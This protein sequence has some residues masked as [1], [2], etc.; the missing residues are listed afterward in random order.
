[1]SAKLAPVASALLFPTIVLAQAAQP[2]PYRDGS[3]WGPWHMMGWGW[4][5]GWIFPLFMIFMIVLCVFF[6]A[7]M[8]AGHGHFHRDDT[9]SALQLLNERFAKGEI[10]KEEFE[11]KRAILGRRP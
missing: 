5:F 7:R 8:F 10:S 11:E 2:G 4:G 6:M 3:D 9:S 1:M